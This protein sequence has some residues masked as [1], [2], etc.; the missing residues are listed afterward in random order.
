MS[1]SVLVRASSTSGSR[2]SRRKYSD[3]ARERSTRPA[4]CLSVSSVS[5]SGSIHDTQPSSSWVKAIG[6]LT[7][8]AAFMIAISLGASRSICGAKRGAEHVQA[9]DDAHLE[10]QER[11]E[12]RE[13]DDAGVRPAG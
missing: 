1:L 13:G 8:L 6:G 12:L 2:T 3:L 4:K 9:G 5:G 7:L 10:R 11:N